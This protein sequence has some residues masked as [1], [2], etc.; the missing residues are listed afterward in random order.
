MQKFTTNS[1]NIV[2]AHY[3]RC[4]SSNNREVL[5]LAKEIFLPEDN[6]VK[7]QR[8]VD[9]RLGDFVA[10][11]EKLGWEVISKPVLKFADLFESAK[12]QFQRK[13]P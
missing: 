1:D 13:L 6:P 10:G 11:V 5:A 8:D 2:K 3:E 12:F 4:N 9:A 7:S